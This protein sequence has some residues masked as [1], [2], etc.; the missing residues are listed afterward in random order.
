MKSFTGV[1]YT[2]Y[3][4]TNRFNGKCYIGQ[5]KCEDLTRRWSGGSGYKGCKFFYSAIQKYG[6]KSFAHEILETGLTAEQANDREQYYIA[7][8]RSNDP[9]FGYNIRK[10]G[11][12]TTTF[13]EEGLRHISECSKGANN[14]NA[15]KVSVFDLTGRR[16]AVTDTARD[17]AKLIGVGMSTLSRHLNQKRG[18]C[19]GYI[20]RFEDEV[21]GVVQL[22]EDQIYFPNEQRSGLRPVAQY[23]KEGN[24]LAV[25]RS[26]KH[27][28]QATGVSRYLISAC[29]SGAQ[30]SAGGFMWRDCQKSPAKI[31]PYTRDWGGRQNAKAVNCYDGKTREFIKTYRS[32]EDAASE[33]GCCGCSIGNAIRRSG[34]SAGYYWQ[35]ADNFPKR[36][37][38]EV[39]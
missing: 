29:C 28:E 13:S 17:A 3:K 6:W 21:P 20:A 38:K 32:I 37:M 24:L 8:Y 27:A 26:R 35:F 15:R 2:I 31:Q 5:T 30:T 16:V 10:G 25:H 23:D 19:G 22:G 11:Q 7:L 1:G 34:T 36:A 9:M 39:L 14:G 4:H 33:I 12:E 18:T